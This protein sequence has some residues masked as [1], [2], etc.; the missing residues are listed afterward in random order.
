MNGWH[1]TVCAAR[2]VS[3]KNEKK[4]KNLSLAYMRVREEWKVRPGVSM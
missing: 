3:L 2:R 4:K 1:R